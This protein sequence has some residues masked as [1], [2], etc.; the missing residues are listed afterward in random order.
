V[1]RLDKALF[2]D[3]DTRAVPHKIIATTGKNRTEQW[4][5]PVL[6]SNQTN[7]GYVWGEGLKMSKNRKRATRLRLL[8]QKS[9]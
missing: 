8:V 4:I 5:N 2:E 9:T 1:E 7:K 3:G 6:P